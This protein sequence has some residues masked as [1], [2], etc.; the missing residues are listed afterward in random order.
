M[1]QKCSHDI[2]QRS[3]GRDRPAPPA[4]PPP[5]PSPQRDAP[6]RPAE[7]SRPGAGGELVSPPGPVSSVINTGTSVANTDS[8]KDTVLGRNPAHGSKFEK[9]NQG[10]EAAAFSLPGKE[11]PAGLRLQKDFASEFPATGRFILPTTAARRS[12]TN[13]QLPGRASWAPRDRSGSGNDQKTLKEQNAFGGA[14]AVGQVSPPPRTKHLL[15]QLGRGK[16]K[17]AKI[18]R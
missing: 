9:R 4:E 1:K 2:G 5:T 16:W 17:M 6:S 3:A 14:T 7:R 18:H 8:E 10:T 13:T 15:T 12:G 11:G